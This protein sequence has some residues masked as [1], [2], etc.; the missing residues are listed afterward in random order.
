MR[1]WAAQMTA[2]EI[3]GTWERYVEGRLVAALNHN[4]K[5]FIKEQTIAGVSGIPTGLARY[6]I[7]GGKRFFDF[8]SMGDLINKAD[9]W[10]GNAANPF[11][12]ID[13]TD[14]SYIDCLSAIRNCAVHGSEASIN[15]YKRNLRS[16]Y[17]I[18]AAP[19]PEEFL[20]AKDFRAASPM[21]YDSRLSGLAFVVTKSIANT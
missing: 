20:H 16:V 3:H 13:A 14:R 9:H 1:R 11:N 15:A 17:G 4:P 10:L 2:V 18:K 19:G 5:H 8:R 21:R 7:R 6:I 12:S